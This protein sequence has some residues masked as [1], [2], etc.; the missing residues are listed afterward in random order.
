MQSGVCVCVR[1]CVSV[2]VSVCVFMC[3]CVYVCVCARAC[4]CLV[5]CMSVHEGLSW[6]KKKN[7]NKTRPIRKDSQQRNQM[8]CF[9]NVTWRSAVKRKLRVL[10]NSLVVWWTCC[11]WQY[12]SC[13]QWRSD[14]AQRWA[15]GESPHC[16][17]QTWWPHIR[18]GLEFCRYPTASP[19]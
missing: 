13:C 8:T 11:S 19:A 15:G 5:K 14:C 3:V 16:A 1:V 6:H 10:V 17:M 9:S 2:S 18:P 4:V 12:E 7:T